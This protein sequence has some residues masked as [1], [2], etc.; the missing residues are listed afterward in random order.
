M[1]MCGAAS[2]FHGHSFLRKADTVLFLQLFSHA[3]RLEAGL[4]ERPKAVFFA[5]SLLITLGNET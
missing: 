3:D 2:Q 1:I 4:A 5:C